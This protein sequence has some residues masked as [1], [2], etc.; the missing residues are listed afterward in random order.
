VVR[1][2]DGE[3]PGR[4]IWGHRDV[5]SGGARAGDRLLIERRIAPSQTNRDSRRLVDGKA[6]L[7]LR[8][9]SWGFLCFDDLFRRPDLRRREGGRLIRDRRQNWQ[10]RVKKHP[11][12]AAPVRKTS[13]QTFITAPVHRGKHCHVEKE[14]VCKNILIGCHGDSRDAAVRLEPA[15]HAGSGST[16]ISPGSGCS[17]RG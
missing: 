2:A 16:P 9:L 4:R 10:G 3:A 15:I 11:R 13:P 12:P 1:I 5:Y 17:S 8:D 7:V 14:R 6:T